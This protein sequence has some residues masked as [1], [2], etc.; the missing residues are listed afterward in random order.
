MSLTVS[1]RPGANVL[2]LDVAF[3]NLSVST[4]LSP[5][6]MT[7]SLLMSVATAAESLVARGA[8]PK[9]EGAL[10]FDDAVPLDEDESVEEA[11][12]LAELEE[13]LDGK[14]EAPA[15]SRALAPTLVSVTL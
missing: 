7:F 12:V 15:E 4:A 11:F 6:S 14:L 10:P 3:A 9:A 13:P 1:S 8:L 2:S 5:V